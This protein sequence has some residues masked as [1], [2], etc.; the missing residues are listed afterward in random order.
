MRHFLPLLF[1]WVSLSGVLA[2]GP[3]RIDRLPPSGILLDSGWTWH[4]GDHPD[5]AKP[6]LDD[7]D[8]S[9]LNPTK[10]IQ[11]MPQVQRAGISWFRLHLTTGH[12]LPPVLVEMT[13][14]VAS[15]VYL[16]GRLLYRFGTISA[17]PQRVQAYNPS[18]AFS[19]PLQPDSRQVLAVRIAYQPGL[20]YNKK[21]IHWNAALLEYI[22]KP[23][24]ELP[25]FSPLSLQASY[26]DSFK[27]GIAFILFV[28]HLSLFIA[29]RRQRANL[30]A[31]GM[32]LLLWLTY[33]ARTANNS[34]HLMEDRMVLYYGSLIDIWIPCFA[35]LTFYS[36]FNFRKGWLFWLAIGSVGFKLLPL[37]ADYQWLIIFFTYYIQIELIRI[38]VVAIRRKLLGA[39]IITVGVL[40]N[41]ILWAIFS[42]LSAF[43]VSVGD[44][45]WL[46]HLLYIA[47]FLC[48]PFTLSLRLALEHGWVNRQLMTKL[49]EVKDLSAKMLTQE[50]EKLKLVAQQNQQL[51][52]TVRER[53]AQL[54]QQTDKLREMDGV[55]SNFFTNLTH[56][57]RTPLTLILGPAERVLAQTGEAETKQQVGLVQRNAQQLLRLIN[58]LLDLSKLEA[59]RMELNSAPGDLISLIRGNFLSFESLAAQKQ[60]SLRFIAA[61]DRLVMA[62]DR[63]KLEKIL[64]NLFA[65][66]LKF[67]PA[68]GDV[69]VSITREQAGDEAWVKLSIQDTGIGI[70]AAKL[71]YVYDRFYQV[72]VSDTREQGGT[73]IGLALTRELVELHGGTIHMA[74]QEGIGTMVTVRL[75]IE[76][77]FAGLTTEPDP[78]LAAPSLAASDPLADQLPEPA[79]GYSAR[80]HAADVP[81]VLLIEDNDD[82][83]AFIRMSMGETYRILEAANGEEGTQLAQQQVPDLVITDLMMPKMNGYQ[84][85]AT[86]KTD[87]RTSHIPV[88][89]LTAKAD[90]DSKVEGLQTGA[91]AYLAK[92]FNQRELLAQVE[93]L[94]TLRRQLRE[95]YSQA[96]RWHTG[97][98]SEVLLP[99][100]EQAFLDRVRA[101]IESHLDDE[102]YSVDRLADA[103]N[104][105]RT[106]LHRKLK[107]VI[108]QSPG[109]LL[110]LVRL[111]RAYDLLKANVGTVAEVAYQVGFGNPL[112][113]STSFS[114]HFGYPPSEVRKKAVAESANHRNDG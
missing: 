24:A 15:E 85:C 62:I 60:I 52:Q 14:A 75:P 40:I 91:D 38:S 92:P 34:V 59:G 73:G 112:N 69:S 111:Q 43:N 82:V 108:N 33:L 7:R 23:A 101:A 90:I 58:Q 84:V 47:A 55:K 97:G 63:D 27:I 96:D 31:A 98:P 8:W 30:Y 74:S 12:T 78:S 61:P 77:E 114:R 86:L 6:D 102:Q 56:E 64:Y 22:L 67:T 2:Q 44:H 80:H 37:P 41:V 57:F 9:L 50:A 113:F 100:M 42:L 89:M 76:Q 65:N 1:F 66:A 72:D 54:Q 53:T 106:Q 11:D 36:L 107:A 3:F 68:G 28:L 93:N 16:D 71:P 46:Y 79:E 20:H 99:S 95:R 25:A 83:R 17:N 13:Q 45:A 10:A 81:L 21:Y 32:Y 39:P 110:R 49:Q 26:L 35:I 48:I 19:L 104:L 4:A 18:A 103:V 94:I 87:E 88:I 109:D 5:W 29:Y 51:E 105:S 70:P